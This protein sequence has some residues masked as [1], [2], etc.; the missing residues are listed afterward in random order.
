MYSFQ[1]IGSSSVRFLGSIR[2]FFLFLGHLL[3]CLFS[4]FVGRV[5]I[6]WFNLA[7]TIY[8]S[9]VHLLWPIMLLAA[10]MGMSLALS[11]YN[12]LSQFYVEYKALPITIN[13]LTRTLLPLLIGI[14][15]S[16]QSGLNLIN[17]RL[18]RLHQKPEEVILEHII[19][20]MTGIFITGLLLYIY[21]IAAFLVGIYF[22]YLYILE[23]NVQDYFLHLTS[24]LALTDL[25]YSMFKTSLNAL[26]VAMVVG[27]YYYELSIRSVSLRKAVSCI[28]TRSIV[29]IILSGAYLIYYRS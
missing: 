7:R 27:Y 16:I 9:G 29:W 26:I 3:T 5:S 12:I 20:I 18:K 25:F 2:I 21:S 19:P 6:Y 4:A 23:I 11:L 14:I 1:Q 28:M 24:N 10:L 8:R 15:L 13:V 17:A 22:A